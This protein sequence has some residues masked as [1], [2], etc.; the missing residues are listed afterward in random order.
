MNSKDTLLIGIG[1]NGRRDDA[2][3]WAFL[4]AIEKSGLFEGEVYYCYQ[5]QIEDAER[6]SRAEHIVFVD[7]YQGHLKE[8][9]EWVSCKPSGNFTFTTHAFTPTSIL[10]LCQELYQKLPPANILMIQGQEWGLG[11]GLSERAQINLQKAL[12]SFYEKIMTKTI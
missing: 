1:N 2:L 3:G 5:L 8:G 10:Y 9:C 7:A 11:E 6:I 4:E 12:S